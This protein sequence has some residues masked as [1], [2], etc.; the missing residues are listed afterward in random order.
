MSGL[1][2]AQFLKHSNDTGGRGQWLREWRKNGKGECTI[3]LH[4]RAPIVPSFSHQ[5]PLAD[6][7]TDKESGK[8]VPVLRWPRFAS[9]DPEIVHRSQFFR[10][11]DGSLRVPPD[12]DPFLLLREWL[13]KADHISLEDPI[14]RWEHPKDRR[15]IVW[16]RGELSGL[17]KRGRANYGNSLDTKIEYIYVVVDD[18]DVEA[19]PVLMREGKLLSQKIAEVVKQQQKQ[20]GE[21][22]GDPMQHPYAIQL[23]AEDASVPL[24]AYKAYKNERSEFTD[25]VWEQISGEEYPDPIRYGE[26][27]D[28]D[29]VKIRD[30]FD[31]AAQVQLP[32]DEIFSDDPAVRRELTRGVKGAAAGAR[33]RPGAGAKAPESDVS[34][35]PPTPRRQPAAAAKAGPQ[36]RRRKVSADPPPEPT[37]PPVET[38]PCDDCG[39]PMLATDSKCS[40]CGAEYEPVESQPPAAKPQ[41]A[42]PAAA[43]PA[44]AKP[45]AAKPAASAKPAG[46]A[47]PGSK[48]QVEQE[49]PAPEGEVDDSKCWSCGA[50][51]G[52][53]EPTCSSCGIEQ[54]DD[55]PF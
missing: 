47:K 26:P 27:Q 48:P 23:I 19:G 24:N 3:W 39:T 38:I 8:Q 45:A 40:K 33:T 4:T 32:L 6:E 16:T 51:V 25:E 18:S 21:V 22:Q 29:L 20:W 41:A 30:A 28:G 2:I 37:P 9:P 15:I 54:G 11:D 35:N 36:T 14:F 5:I 50:D 49:P 1:G 42:K 52:P 34:R 10:E 17:V 53:D 55:I 44:A 43:K 46:R 12:R 7:Y 13:R 31:S